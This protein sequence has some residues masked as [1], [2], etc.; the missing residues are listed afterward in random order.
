MWESTGANLVDASARIGSD[1]KTLEVFLVN[2]DLEKDIETTVR[3]SGGQVDGPVEMAT[4]IA[5]SLTEWNSFEKPDRVKIEHS[6]LAINQGELRILLPSH[7][8]SRL[9]VRLT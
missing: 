7:S 5:S 8:V 6:Q 3:L 2:R 4:L 9:N 1:G